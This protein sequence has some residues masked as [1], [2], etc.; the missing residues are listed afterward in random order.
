MSRIVITAGGVRAVAELKS[1][2]ERGTAHVLGLLPLTAKLSHATR[3]GNC[4]IASADALRDESVGVETQVSMYYPGMLALDAARGHLVL[5][6][7]QGQARSQTGT[8]WVT[9]LGDVVEGADDLAVKLQ[10]TR[11]VGASEIRFELGD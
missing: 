4:A 1:T 8:H 3:S 10:E 6:Y 11:D 9:Y 7:G 5:A 2:S